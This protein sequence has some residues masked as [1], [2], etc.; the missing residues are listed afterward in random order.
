[1][2]AL[3]IGKNGKLTGKSERERRGL[4]LD[5]AKRNYVSNSSVIFVLIDRMTT[6][7][8]W[9]EMLTESIM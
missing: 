9:P 7:K 1:M 8:G 3:S 5:R 6:K 4:S 2:I